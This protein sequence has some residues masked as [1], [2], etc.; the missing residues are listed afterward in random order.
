MSDLTGELLAGGCATPEKK[1]AALKLLRGEPRPWTRDRR[2]WSDRP[3]RSDAEGVRATVN[4]CACS[5]WRWE[6]RGMSWAGD[7][8]SG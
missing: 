8:G 2:R 5:L 7:L 1:E 4:V 3:S 6:C